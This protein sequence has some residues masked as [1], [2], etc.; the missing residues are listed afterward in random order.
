MRLA[1]WHTY[2]DISEVMQRL[3]SW[4]YKGWGGEVTPVSRH[5][6]TCRWAQLPRTVVAFINGAQ[7]LQEP[8][9]PKP[10]QLQPLQH[11]QPQRQLTVNFRLVATFYRYSWLTHC[12]VVWLH[13]TEPSQRGSRRHTRGPE[14]RHSYVVAPNKNKLHSLRELIK[15]NKFSQNSRVPWRFS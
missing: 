3:C 5:N 7:R 11:Q 13:S 15:I 6:S 14:N 9:P 4:E 2:V 1:T 8:P 10:P 12:F